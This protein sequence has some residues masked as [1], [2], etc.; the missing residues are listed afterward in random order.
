[1]AT[2]ASILAWKIPWTEE[3][4]GLQSMGLK[5]VGCDQARARRHTHTHTHTHTELVYNV[6]VVSGVQQIESVINIPYIYSFFFFK[7]LFPYRPLKSIEQSSLCYTVGPYQLSI[8]YIVVCICLEK[9][10][11]THSGILAWRI[12]TDR[13]YWWVTVHGSQRVRHD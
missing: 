12:P 2:H 1:M 6:V 4:G 10:M 11:A 13:G 7:I 5:R 3:P 8:L 9:G